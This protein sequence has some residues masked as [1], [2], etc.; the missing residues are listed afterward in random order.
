[1]PGEP[2]KAACAPVRTKD[3]EADDEYDPALVK[4][5]P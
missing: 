4:T 5:G 2:L 3:N 1:M